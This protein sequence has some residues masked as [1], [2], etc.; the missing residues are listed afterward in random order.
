VTKARVERAFAVVAEREARAGAEPGRRARGAYA[1]PP[2]LVRFVVARA[3]DPLFA[4]C[5][6]EGRGIE[7]LRLLDPSC[8][9]GAFLIGALERVAAA[10]VE[11]GERRGRALALAAGTLRGIDVDE[12]SV[13]AARRAIDGIAGPGARI[14]RA[15]ALDDR[16][17]ARLVGERELDAVIGNP[18]Y[19]RV[20]GSR[21]ALL[22]AR[23]CSLG[24]RFGSPRMDVW[25][26]FA[27]GA[28]EA[29]AP[30]GRH[31]FVVPA[32]FLGAASA[33]ELRR[34]L[35]SD[36]R[37]ETLLDLGPAPL[38][39]DVVG[40]HVADVV[41]RDEGRGPVE[42]IALEGRFDEDV[43]HALATD[44]PHP[45]L[46]RETVALEE[47]L[48][49][50]G[51]VGG[52]TAALRAIAS[53]V[54]RAG[55][56]ADF[57]VGEGVTAGPDVWSSGLARRFPRVRAERGEGVF[58]VDA[59]VSGLERRLLLPFALPRDVP[60]AS[61]RILY[62]TRE[63]LP[64]A[65][66][67]PAIVRHLARFREALEA[68]REVQRGT[69]RFFDLHWPRDRT[70]FRGPRVLLPRMCRR[71]RAW[72]V[73]APLVVGES[74]LVLKPRSR[75]QARAVAA[76]LSTAPL[77]AFLLAR[78][79]RRGVGIDVSVALAR[80]IPWPRE[81]LELE[82]L[83]ATHPLALCVACFE[84]GDMTGADEAASLAYG[85][86]PTLVREA[87]GGSP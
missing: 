9:A 28:L 31:A 87:L 24:R 12:K 56:R 83:S 15:D 86:D 46:A 25:Y 54:E 79:K 51:T 10:L 57:L 16:G 17:L 76:L 44:A 3:L 73:S 71:P 23:A 60:R 69:R 78:G 19:L 81:L 30:G 13:R 47:L 80:A 11:R 38:F 29:L 65:E 41:S 61:G 67:A 64:R 52:A 62:I 55:E 4:R 63:T 82:R 66:D 45:A 2:E 75:D 37:L 58:V 36:H 74:V 77:A 53:R 85:L 6:A 20:K 84:R 43:A 72:F 18:P 34:A 22:R 27:H 40:R 49:E 33:L 59:H 5:D 32:Y 26:L 1:T 7:T 70:L 42:R 68:R 50:G 39:K 8:G 21:E 14:V 35:F 48:G